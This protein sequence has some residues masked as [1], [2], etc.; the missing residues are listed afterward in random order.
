M[1]VATVESPCAKSSLISTVVNKRTYW[2]YTYLKS[3]FNL[4]NMLVSCQMCLSL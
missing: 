2:F 3:V 1:N 4:Q